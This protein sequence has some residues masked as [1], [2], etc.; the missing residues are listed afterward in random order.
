MPN[1]AVSRTGQRAEVLNAFMR[2]VYF[3]M[4]VGLA[5]T[6]AVAWVTAQTP[7]LV[8]FIY[9]NTMVLIVLV[10][11]QLGLVVALSGAVRKMSGTTA[12]ALFLLYSGLTGLTFA[13][14]LLVYTPADIFKAFVTAAG[15]FGAMSVYGMTTKRDLTSWGSFLFMGLIGLVIAMVVNMFLRSPVMDFVISGVG[16]LIFTGLTAYDTQTLKDMGENMPSADASVIRR[17]V[18]LGALRLYLDFINLFLMLLR[19]FGGRD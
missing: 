10:V 2:G 9:A 4:F 13:A 6:S 18:I 1:Q 15:M 19:L 11:A 5:L 16:V 17:G 8:Q 14:I 3:W 12:T 7:A